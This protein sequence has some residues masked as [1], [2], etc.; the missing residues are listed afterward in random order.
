MAENRGQLLGRLCL[1]GLGGMGR[2]VGGAL[3]VNRFHREAP[4]GE[5]RNSTGG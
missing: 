5:R 3:V 1:A 2:G 4:S